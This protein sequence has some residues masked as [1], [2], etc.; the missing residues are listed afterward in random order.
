ME[1]QGKKLLPLGTGNAFGR[2]IAIQPD[3][4]SIMAIIANNGT[5]ND[6]AVLRL[7]PEGQPD[8]EFGDSG[9]II[10]DFDSRTDIAE[11]IALDDMNR[12]IVAGSIENTTGFDFGVAR[13]LPDGNLD[14]SFSDDGLNTTEV[15]VTGFCKAVAVQ[16]DNKI[17]LGGYAIN[18]L[19]GTNEFVLV[20]YRTDGVIDST[21]DH[22]G[23][24]KT[25]MDIGSGV[26]NAM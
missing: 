2:S 26:A 15:G 9:M 24:V 18:P 5:S 17:V 22:D 8:L 21:F 4:K 7:T 12:I 6:F 10:T 16:Q 11:A 1:D 13:Y 25:N 3:G 14:E 19:N 23:I 20:R